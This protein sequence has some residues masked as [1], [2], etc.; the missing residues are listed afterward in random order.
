[1]TNM[2]KYTASII[3]PNYNGENLLPKYLPYICQ[4]AKNPKNR[5]IEIIVVDDCSTDRSVS[6]ISS[7]FPQV[8]LIRHKVNR[9]FSAAVN[10]GVRGAKG[11]IVVLI[12]TDVAPKPDFLEDIIEDFS[13]S[14][15][16]G[17][18]LHEKGYSWAKG[19]F[20]NGFIVHKLGAESD[21]KETTFWVS[22]GSGAF[23][24][25][26]WIELGGFDEKLYS[27]FYWEDV[28]ISYRAA[29]RGYQLL[30]E[31]KACVTHEHESTVGTLNRVWVNRILERNQLLFIWKNIT[32][33]SLIRKHFVGLFK[34]V[35][36]HPGYLR[37]VLAA[38]SKIGD[39]IRLRKKEIKEERV[40][41]EAIL[42][43]FS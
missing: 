8:K 15:V 34:R 27:P 23:R 42:A 18:S 26:I 11:N 22:G 36:R 38:L 33:K 3:I 13:D 25:R 41:D 19:A 31:P 40:S 30:W 10:T 14:S 4:A 39:V 21:K 5:V 2:D 9:G 43:R 29:K 17:V 1:M 16:F 24:R 37:V 35:I 12:N 28:D 6:V 20:E 32:S 7:N